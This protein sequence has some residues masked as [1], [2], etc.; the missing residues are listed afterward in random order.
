MALTRLQ[1]KKAPV[2]SDR[3][4]LLREMVE[5]ELHTRPTASN[6]LLPKLPE[7]PLRVDSDQLRRW[8]DCRMCSLR[9]WAKDSATDPD[10]GELAGLYNPR[11]QQWTDHFRWAGVMVIPL[12]DSGRVTVATLAMN[13]SIML[14][15]RHEE[16]TRGRHPPP[17]NNIETPL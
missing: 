10:T 14:S 12:T 11:T 9:K 2:S 5:S 15:I 7:F 1:R 16:A 8:Y 6:K 3:M 13:R 4:T 17:S